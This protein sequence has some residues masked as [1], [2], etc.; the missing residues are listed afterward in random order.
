MQEDW[1]L[2]N[3]SGDLLTADDGTTYLLQPPYD[4][5]ADNGDLLTNAGGDQ[6]VTY[7]G[8]Y[9]VLADAN[10]YTLTGRAAGLNVSIA[11]GLITDGGLFLT[12][13]AGD[14][15]IPDAIDGSLT[16][17]QGV[18]LT[19]DNGDQ[20]LADQISGQDYTFYP[21]T[22]VFTVTRYPALLYGRLIVR[23]VVVKEFTWAAPYPAGLAA[24]HL[25]TADTASYA[26]T[27]YQMTPVAADSRMGADAAQFVVSGV[28]TPL[29]ATR[30][31]VQASPATF[32]V[33][34]Y[35]VTWRAGHHMDAETVSFALAG[36]EGALRHYKLEA[37]KHAIE[38]SSHGIAF[39]YRP[40][41]TKAGGDDAPT[42]VEEFTEAER[43][44]RR[45]W[46]EEQDD[47]DRLRAQLEGRKPKT[48]R[49]APP[50]EKPAPP[51]RPKKTPPAPA[52]QMDMA[53]IAA[54]FERARQ[55]AIAA[56]NAIAAQL[57][58][59]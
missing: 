28:E 19:A 35:D 39:L 37:W 46:R 21:D 23:N 31:I 41:L 59:F 38:I 10:S 48:K 2:L 40:I 27:G 3:G 14:Y 9:V 17:D 8:S 13:D 7:S 12:N 22:G 43:A 32:D 49:A 15:L 16:D 4:L 34:A 11:D 57:L 53:L 51:V 44:R 58:L 52:P 20:L 36:S 47:R 56:Q 29:F 5:T 30:L 55:A 25:F 26:L 6:L 50:T 42:S 45:R 24:A 54:E 18:F 33:T 1:G